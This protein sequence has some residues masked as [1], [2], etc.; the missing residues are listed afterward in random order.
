M[1]A[2]VSAESTRLPSPQIP[3]L[4]QLDKALDIPRLAKRHSP[5]GVSWAVF[6]TSSLYDMPGTYPEAFKGHPKQ[7]S[8]WTQMTPFDVEKGAGFTSSLCW[9]AEHFT[10]SCIECSAGS[11]WEL[12]LALA[13]LHLHRPTIARSRSRS[14]YCASARE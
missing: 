2:A 14:T 6:L 3:P 13:F 8:D 10:I 7:T 11:D 4:A 1:W 5:S 9:I 12:F